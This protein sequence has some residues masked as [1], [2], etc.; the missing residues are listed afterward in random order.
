MDQLSIPISIQPEPSDL[1]REDLNVADVHIRDQ[2]TFNYKTLY[3]VSDKI[4][5][6]YIM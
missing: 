5:K 4:I 3:D 1:V 6:L 2:P